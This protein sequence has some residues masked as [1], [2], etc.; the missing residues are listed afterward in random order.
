VQVFDMLGKSV[1]K[2]QNL[3]E[4]TLYE[5]ATTGLSDGIY[6]VSLQGVN[7]E[8]FTQKVVVSNSK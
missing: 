2:K 6:V 3:G 4:N 8:K 7:N 5:L 1:L